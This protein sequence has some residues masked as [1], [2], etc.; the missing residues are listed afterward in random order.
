VSLEVWSCGG[1]TQSAAI[2]ALICKGRLPKPDMAVM[3]DVERE[4]SATWRYAEAVLI[5]ELAKIGVNLVIKK[6]SEFTDVDIYSKDERLVLIPAFTL[7]NGQVGKGSAFCSGEWKRDV[8]MR[9]L[10]SEGVESC[11]NWL[12][13]SLDEVSRV[14]GPRRKWFQPHYP[15]I[16]DVPMT[17]ADCIHLVVNEMGWP[18][19][20]K[21]ACKMC[22]NHDHQGWRR[23][24]QE[25]P[26]DFAYAVQ[27]DLDLRKTHPH[28][29]LHTSCV[30]LGEVDFSSDSPTG[31]GDLF[32]TNSCES[33]YCYV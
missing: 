12:G 21:T 13:I 19:A 33:G 17:K 14:R 8:V 10:R 31:Q 1:G 16:F 29:Y 5:P 20:P 6:K 22:P 30:P 25:D 23:M 28:M 7:L 18:E 26:E 27:F 15:L 3:I 32:R 11:R 4:K 24:K 9:Y 2:A